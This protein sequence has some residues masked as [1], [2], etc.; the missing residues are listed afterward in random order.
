MLKTMLTLKIDICH[1]LHTILES[2]KAFAIIFPRNFVL[3]LTLLTTVALVFLAS[4]IGNKPHSENI[5]WFPVSFPERFTNAYQ[6]SD[7]K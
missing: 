3:D 2:I 7:V 4:G 1:T 6:Y 5:N